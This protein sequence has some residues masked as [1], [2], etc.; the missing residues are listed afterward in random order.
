MR[1]QNNLYSSSSAVCYGDEPSLI[2]IIKL[3]TSHGFSGVRT[4]CTR[5]CQRTSLRMWLTRHGAYFF[6]TDNCAV[7]VFVG[8]LLFHAHDQLCIMSSLRSGPCFGR[9]LCIFRTTL[10]ITNCRCIWRSYSSVNNESWLVGIHA[11]GQS[12]MIFSG[13]AVVRRN[14]LIFCMKLTDAV[15][16]CYDFTGGS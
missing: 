8:A 1:K 10:R 15:Y 13:V 5:S 11:Q 3:S 16:D 2:L 6:L 4:R 14:G 9:S 7:L 12:S